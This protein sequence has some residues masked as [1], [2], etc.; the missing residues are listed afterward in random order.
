LATAIMMNKKSI[1]SIA[2]TYPRWQHDTIPDFVHELNKR[3]TDDF[4]VVALVPYCKNARRKEEMDGVHVY[5][6]KYLPFDWGTL[7]YE[8]G[9]M[10]NIKK[11]WLIILQVPFFLA[12]QFISINKL[13]RENKICILHTHWLIPQGLIAVIYKKI[14]NKKIK[15]LT[16]IHGTDIYGLGNYLGRMIKKFILRNIDSVTAVSTAIKDE[17]LKFEY[18]KTITVCPMGTDTEYFSPE[19]RNPALREEL[20]IGDYFL[21]FVGRLSETKGLEYLLRAMPEVLNQK[22]KTKLIVIGQ[23]TLKA[24]LES[25][26]RS[27]HITENVTFLGPLRHQ[28]LPEYF[29]TADLFIGPSIQTKNGSEGFGLV[30]AEAMSCGTPVI[31]TDLPAMRDIVKDGIS[32]FIVN[33]KDPKAISDRIL[34]V[35]NHGDSLEQMKES[36]RE[37]IIQNYDWNIISKKYIDILWGLCFGE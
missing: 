37:H 1:L 3:L 10:P 5:R 32:G 14:F 34:F 15:I 35:L 19:K 33:Q 18:R 2:S 26:C 27:L 7:A 20:N 28:L 21:L 29:A 16:T 25:L 31:T 23:G 6:Y 24:D 22:P 9:I 13:V 11:N 36:A 17:V 12:C 8:G 30:F 4:D